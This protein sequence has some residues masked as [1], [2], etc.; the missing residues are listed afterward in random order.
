[1]RTNQECLKHRKSTISVYQ[2]ISTNIHT[3]NTTFIYR[4][5]DFSGYSCYSEDYYIRF[6]SIGNKKIR[7]R[8]G[9]TIHTY[10]SKI[11]FKQQTN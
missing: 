6:P 2:A 5:K 3:Y 11:K 9:G 10:I 7:S 4:R 8:I 1:M